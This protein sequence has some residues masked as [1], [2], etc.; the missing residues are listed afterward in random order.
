MIEAAA[1]AH[2]MLV[3]HTKSGKCFSGV[4][5]AR[6]RSRDGVHEF[7]RQS[8]YTAHPLQNVQYHAL[9]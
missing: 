8:G 9:A 4:E 7:T 2:C 6:V 5:D 1:A 3:Q